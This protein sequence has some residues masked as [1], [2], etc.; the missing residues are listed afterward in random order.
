MLG[1]C[2]NGHAYFFFYIFMKGWLQF[3][4]KCHYI[5]QEKTSTYANHFWKYNG[6]SI[7]LFFLL[8][9]QNF[10]K[11][12]FR[13]EIK[14]FSFQI[15]FKNQFSTLRSG[16][17]ENTQIHVFAYFSFFLTTSQSWKLIPKADLK[18]ECPYFYSNFFLK[19]IGQYLKMDFPLYFQKVIWLA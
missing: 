12:K 4:M 5:L 11:K 7:S 19:S 6:K 2:K 14:A 16:Q 9:D 8:I 3:A 17:T 15:C 18:R 10:S 1:N 13:I